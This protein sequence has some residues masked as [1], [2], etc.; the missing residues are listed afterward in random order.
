MLLATRAGDDRKKYTW[1]EGGRY[2]F[3]GCAFYRRTRVV[4]P[5]WVIKSRILRGAHLSP[6]A[7]RSVRK[8][9]TALSPPKVRDFKTLFRECLTDKK[10]ELHGLASD[11]C[12][13]LIILI[14]KS[15]G[16]LKK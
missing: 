14:F 6:A 3:T 12:K 15:F 7:Q 5:F 9:T 16:L 13:G 2:S 11:N 1:E 10:Y 4:S 8:T